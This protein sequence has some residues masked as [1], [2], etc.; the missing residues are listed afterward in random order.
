MFFLML[1]FNSCSKSDNIRLLNKSENLLIQSADSALFLLESIELPEE[2]PEQYYAKYCKL[3]VSAHIKNK[4]DIKFDTLIRYAV[5]YYNKLPNEKDNYGES[6]L[7][8]GNVY[9]E[10]E[11]LKSAEKCYKDVHLLSQETN[12]AYLFQESAFELGGL[13]IDLCQY[14]EAISWFD[15][16]KE[17]AVKNEDSV[18]QHRTMRHAADCYALLGK[19]DT[20]LVIYNKVLSQIPPEKNCLRAEI[21]K[22]IA[23]VYKNT[24]R[25]KESL[26]FIQKSIS[27]L[28]KE[29]SPLQYIILSSIYENIG[30]QDSSK[31]YMQKALMYAKEQ[32]SVNTIYR[33][34]EFP[35]KFDNYLL[36]NSLSD[37]SYLKLKY[38]TV[39][40]QHLYNVEKIKKKNKELIIERQRYL[41][42]LIIVIILFIIF[43][44][45]FREIRRRKGSEY[46]EELKYKDSIINS[47]RHTLYL[48]LELYIK[49][50][51]L[52]ISP[53]KAKHK[54]FLSEYN[55]ILFGR[56]ED[57]SIDWDIVIELTNKVF[58]DYYNKIG[59]LNSEI[60]EAET[61]IIMLLKLGFSVSE[62]ATIFEKSIH[63]IYRHC[64]NIRK[65]L[66]IPEAESITVF[67][68][69][70]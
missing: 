28:N 53:N 43:L 25:H 27:L 7:L 13:H 65:K 49:M 57:F 42:I 4:I 64:S 68:E 22:N 14:E 26:D 23:I 41:F 34:Y 63:T 16:A 21:Y 61:R 15:T 29:S 19:T 56:Q 70:K 69:K 44:L 5:D 30:Q 39:K 36:T 33:A 24:K 51:K 11:N 1:L 58:D 18:M 8:L 3:L 40:Y 55:K 35:E 9:E 10:Q 48:R 66:N 45:Y 52:S 2:M 38:T 47:M 60:N 20:A 32:G 31:Y 50:V 12:N 6:L 46:Q 17:A 54:D 62:I 37:S 67:F 59:N